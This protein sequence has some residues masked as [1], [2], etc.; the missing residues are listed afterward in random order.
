MPDLIFGGHALDEMQRDSVSADEVYLVV[1]DADVEY[2]RN[3]GPTRYE[4]L[5]D[6]GRYIVV[7]VQDDIQTVITVW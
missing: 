5:L 6:D 4:R 2:E 3:D 1:G 7:M